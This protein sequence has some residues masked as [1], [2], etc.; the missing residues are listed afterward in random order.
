M[1]SSSICSFSSSLGT[2][3]LWSRFLGLIWIKGGKVGF[4]EGGKPG[5]GCRGW[6]GCKLERGSVIGVK[7]VAKGDVDAWRTCEEDKCVFSGV[8]C[9]KLGGGTCK[10]GGGTCKEGGE[11]CKV[12]GGTCKEGRGWGTCKEGWG[13]ERGTCIETEFWM[14]ES[15]DKLELEMGEACKEEDVEVLWVCAERELEEEEAIE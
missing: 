11:T 15:S 5:L 1:L 9:R 7:G 10:E 6:L 14:R 3:L 13:K 2:F 12:G 4:L 8:V